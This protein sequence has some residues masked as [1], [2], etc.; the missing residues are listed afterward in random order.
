MN[1]FYS[2][3]N[4]NRS[5]HRSRDYDEQESD[6]LDPFPPLGSKRVVR[7]DSAEREH[8]ERSPGQNWSEEE[9][10]VR[11]DG[12]NGNRNRANARLRENRSREFNARKDSTQRVNEVSND[13]GED[14]DANVVDNQK[15]GQDI[16]SNRRSHRH[17]K[18][19][20]DFGEEPEA[21]WGE[22]STKS[23]H[24]IK[25]ES[26]WGR[27]EATDRSYQ[28][29]GQNRRNDRPQQDREQRSEK[30]TQ[31]QGQGYEIDRS[32]QD[33]NFQSNRQYQNQDQRDDKSYH[34]R[35]QGWKN[36]RP[37]QNRDRRNN[38]PYQNQGPDRRND[39]SHQNQDRRTNRSYQNQDGQSDGSFQN[40]GQDQR[41]RR[42]ERPRQDNRSRYQ[43]RRNDFP[44]VGNQESDDRGVDSAKEWNTEEDWGKEA[45]QVPSKL[46]SGKA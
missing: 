45:E 39:R 6:G 41:N 25:H 20:E 13:W 37:P 7:R 32:G 18:D 17:S 19:K 28:N 11:D 23:R 12:G 35:R 27:D 24:S 15:R 38:R 16:H 1:L 36:E 9:R 42:D 44:P 26:K 8:V 2:F 40:R 5:S 4:D 22:E 3:R 34:N 29:Q 33:P 31:S 30:P 14:V 21:A 43:N 10:K 46:F